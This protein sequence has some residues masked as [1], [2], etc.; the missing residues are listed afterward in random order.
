MSVRKFI[1]IA[2][3]LGLTLLALG[4]IKAGRPD[5]EPEWR[6]PTPSTTP[7]SRLRTATQGPP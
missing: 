7:I 6:V 2:L 1:I 3:V 4:L 5:N